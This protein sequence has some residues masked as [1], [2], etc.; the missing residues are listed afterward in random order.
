M[1]P[2]D[3]REVIVGL[4]RHAGPSG[5]TADYSANEIQDMAQ[6]IAAEVGTFRANQFRLVNPPPLPE[7][8]VYVEPEEEP[9]AL[10]ANV[11]PVRWR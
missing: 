10:V 8:I 1:D 7:Q 9:G 11:K 5:D 6:H 4:V 3:L 2:E